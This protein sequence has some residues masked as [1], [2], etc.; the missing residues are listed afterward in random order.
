VWVPAAVYLATQGAY[1]QVAI[2]ATAGAGIAFLD[3]ITR[4]ILI[5]ERSQLHTLVVFFSVLG[6]LQVF[7]LLGIIVGPLIAALGIVILERDRSDV[8]MT[9]TLP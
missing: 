7:G 5:G 9:S 4:T 1:G 6:G 3:Y 8:G 2:L